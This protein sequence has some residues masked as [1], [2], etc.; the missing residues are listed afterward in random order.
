M[1]SGTLANLIK[2]DPEQNEWKVAYTG[3]FNKEKNSFE[4]PQY[5]TYFSKTNDKMQRG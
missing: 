5:K 4:K 3:K 2:Y 1:S